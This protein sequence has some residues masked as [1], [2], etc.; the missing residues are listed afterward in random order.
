MQ[1]ST[2]KAD[3]GARLQSWLSLAVTSLVRT[4]TASEALTWDA[5]NRYVYVQGRSSS[6]EGEGGNRAPAS[7]GPISLRGLRLSLCVNRW[8]HKSDFYSL[9]L[10]QTDDLAVPPTSWTLFQPIWKPAWLKS[11]HAAYAWTFFKSPYNCLVSTLSARH[12]SSPMVRAH[13]PLLA[14]NRCPTRS[15][16]VA[17]GSRQFVTLTF[18]DFENRPMQPNRSLRTR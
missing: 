2:L 10:D 7:V 11:V 4:V 16:T 3:V 5:S 12:A 18:I 14:C 9:Q 8:Q 13:S 15:P 1:Q 6:L 17:A